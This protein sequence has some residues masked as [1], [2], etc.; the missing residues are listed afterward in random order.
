MSSTRFASL[1]LLA[2]VAGTL[3]QSA[4]ATVPYTENFTSDA[5]NWRDGAGDC[6]GHLRRKRRTGRQ[7]LYHVDCLGL[8]RRRRRSGCRLSRPRRVQFEWRC[9]RRQLAG[10]RNQPV[11][12][13]G[14]GTMHHVPLDFFVR[15]ATAGNFPGTA[16][17]KGALIAPNTWTQLSY[18]IAP[19]R[20]STNYLFP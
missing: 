6:R 15:F 12:A 11:S 13:F 8:F 4:Y 5:A 17:D 7:Q 2:A 9:V 1:A 16:A 18:E 20:I 10:K 3:S 14:F 19:T